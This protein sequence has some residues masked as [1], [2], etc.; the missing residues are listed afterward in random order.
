MIQLTGY[1]PM[2]DLGATIFFQLVG[3]H[4]GRGSL[5]LSLSPLDVCSKLSSFIDRSCSH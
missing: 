2:D 5:T 3:A 4:H 1:L